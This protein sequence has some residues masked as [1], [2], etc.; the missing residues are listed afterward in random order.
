MSRFDLA[1]KVNANKGLN[2]LLGVNP[3]SE[4]QF[5][6]PTTLNDF[7]E[8]PF[9]PHRGDKFKKLVES[10]RLLG[11]ISPLIIRK[12]GLQTLSGHNRRNGAI[13][14]GLNKVPCIVRDI[15]YDTASIIVVDS[16]FQQRDDL[17]ISEKAYGYK[18]KLEAMQR[19]GKHDDSIGLKSRD[20]VGREYGDS[21]S[22]VQR[23]LRMTYLTDTLLNMVD[24]NKIAFNIAVEISYLNKVEQE[25]LASFLNDNDINIKMSQAAEMKY[26]S[27]NKKLDL[28]QIKN[29]L[30][31]APTSKTTYFKLPAN[32]FSK[33]FEKD[34]NEKQVLDVIEKALKQY[35]EK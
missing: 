19:K 8:H 30:V 13:E 26:Y 25:L 24:E 28:V 14:A 5:L 32:N 35:F 7:P 17:L 21:G 15:D 6:V 31:S 33:Y 3:E 11:I 16:N 1:S 10:I 22:Q 9:K 20:I 18:M 27:K 12:E 23:Y 29:I 34:A 4:I 2:D